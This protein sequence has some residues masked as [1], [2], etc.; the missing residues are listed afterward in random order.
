MADGQKARAIRASSGALS[1]SV[2]IPV[3]IS[4]RP[5]ASHRAPIITKAKIMTE[6]AGK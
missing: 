3:K 1:T 5:W 4:P 2:P 6:R